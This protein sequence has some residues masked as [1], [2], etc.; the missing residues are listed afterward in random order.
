[1][2]DALSFRCTGCGNCCRNLRVAVTALDVQRLAHATGKAAPTLVDWL[3]PAAVD[4]SGEPD[5][6]VELSEGRRLMV[7]AQTS[8]ACVLL[9]SDDSCRAYAARPRDCQAY[10]FDF[11]EPTE[12]SA[13]RHLTLLPLD[14]CEYGEDGNNDL[15][16]LDAVD[17]VRFE[18]LARYRA[19]VARWNRL[20]FHRRRLRQPIGRAAE[21]LRFVLAAES[22]AADATSKRV[23]AP[24]TLVKSDN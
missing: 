13:K 9:A 15:A 17:R 18:E 3:A 12:L 20:A 16:E 24:A 7:L 2:V 5:S 6:F 23:D 10:P 19:Q 1:M 21:F 22:D 4:M 11:E 8:G 14:A